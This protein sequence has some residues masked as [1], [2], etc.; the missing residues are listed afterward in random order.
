METVII[1]NVDIDDVGFGIRSYSKFYSVYETI[2]LEVV[3]S[4]LAIEVF[5]SFQILC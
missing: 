1:D 2:I 3:R 5:V 4:L